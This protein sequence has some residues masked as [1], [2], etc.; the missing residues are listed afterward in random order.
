MDREKAHSRKK[1]AKRIVPVTKT[2]S[3]FC[4]SLL[5]MLNIRQ[6]IFIRIM[7]TAVTSNKTAVV[8]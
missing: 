1:I 2:N 7:T 4:A 3:Q 5:F 6:G 8:K